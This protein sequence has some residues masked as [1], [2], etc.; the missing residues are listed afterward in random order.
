MLKKRAFITIPICILLSCAIC[1]SVYLINIKP[2]TSHISTAQKVAEYA[3]P[4]VVKIVNYAVVKWQFTNPADYEVADYLN[5]MNNETVVGGSGSGFMISEDGHI[6]TNAHVVETNKMD[7]TEIVQE[8]FDLLVKQ[9]SNDFQI[10]SKIVESYMLQYTLYSDVKKEL[11][12][13]LPDGEKKDGQIKSYGAP[14]GEGKDVAVLKI[15]GHHFPTLKIG[16]SNQISL[17]DN[18]WVFGYPAAADS[19]L[20]SEDSDKVVSITDGKISATDKK[21]NEGN[22]VIQIS[23]PSTHG[24]SGGPVIS[25]NGTVIGIL[26]FRGDTVNGQEVQG[27]NFAVPI[28]TV[29][30]FILQAGA[31]NKQTKTDDLYRDGLQL[32]WG[33]YY[34]DA[35]TK[36]QQLH[37]HYPEH[38]EVKRWMAKAKEKAGDSKILWS[39]YQTYF[40]LADIVFALIILA[41]LVWTFLAKKEEKTE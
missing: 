8:A 17:Q 4:A 5:K 30:E 10:D 34:K 1:F 14:V 25:E 6:I 9:M 18:V 16:D 22:P 31:K 21:S 20:L 33:G 3:K 15:A 11:K 36:F 26:T 40:I 41:L 29:K 35:L 7:E 24:N 37:A 27:F 12:V 13:I 23:A 38:S 28:N 19:D 32:Y 2:D 39:T